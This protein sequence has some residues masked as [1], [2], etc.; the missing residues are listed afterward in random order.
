MANTKTV[1]GDFKAPV[2][3]T[4]FLIIYHENGWC[5]HLF[6]ILQWNAFEP[7]TPDS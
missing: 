4:V 7:L 2:T 6:L 1:F 5:H 3:Q